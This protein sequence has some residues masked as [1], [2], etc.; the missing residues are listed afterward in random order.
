MANLKKLKR[1]LAKLDEKDFKEVLD[2]F[3]DEEIKKEEVKVE[4]KEEIKEDIQETKKEVTKE[5]PKDEKEVLGITKEDLESILSKF[6]EKFVQKDEFEKSQK[7]AKAFG[8][9]KKQEKSE[10]TEEIK[11][12][13]YLSK[14]N[15][16]FV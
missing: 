11:I 8:A 2:L 1:E 5:E 3:V 15:S 14:V 10:Q 12:E 16:Q 6:T 4:V 9:D 7:K 13:D